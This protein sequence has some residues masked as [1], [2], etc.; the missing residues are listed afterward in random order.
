MVVYEIVSDFRRFIHVVVVVVVIF[1]VVVVVI[2]VV[3]VVV[4]SV[5]IN[6]YL[7]CHFT[8]KLKE[9]FYRD[10]FQTVRLL[11]SNSSFFLLPFFFLSE[12]HSPFT[13]SAKVA[14]ITLIAIP[15]RQ[16]KLFA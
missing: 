14:V 15:S 12:I 11:F 13:W 6:L 7:I 8:K 4:V 1:I 9:L 16:K 2:V 10:S 3:I 5:V